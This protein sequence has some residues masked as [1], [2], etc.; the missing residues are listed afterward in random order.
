LQKQKVF[1]RKGDL[2]AKINGTMTRGRGGCPGPAERGNY[3][4]QDKRAARR[5]RDMVDLH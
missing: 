3:G 4:S 1:Q 2:W 5:F